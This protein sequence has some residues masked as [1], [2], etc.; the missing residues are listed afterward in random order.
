M[1]PLPEADCIEAVRVA[2]SPFR[3]RD[4]RDGGYLWEVV[5]IERVRWDD[6]ASER[7]AGSEECLL[8]LDPNH[9]NMPARLEV[10]RLAGYAAAAIGYRCCREDVKQLLSKSWTAN[11]DFYVLSSDG[12]FLGMRTH[13]D[14]GSDAGM[15]IPRGQEPNKAPEPTPMSVTPPAAREPRQP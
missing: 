1:T 10:A 2:L 11:A 7:F 4:V 12:C 5:S 9:W 15:W 13:E 6:A 8:V 3:M 14:T